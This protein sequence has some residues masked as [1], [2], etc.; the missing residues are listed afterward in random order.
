MKNRNFIFGVLTLSIF[1]L[2]SVG[3]VHFEKER[4]PS[5]LAYTLQSTWVAASTLTGASG[6]SV[7][8]TSASDGGPGSLRQALIDAQNG[9]TI[10]FDPTIF[11]P[12]APTK[13]YLKS[14][15]LEIVQGY[16]TIDASNAGVILDGSKSTAE[17]PSGIT[18]RSGGNTIRG[19]KIINFNGPGIILVGRAQHNTIGGDRDVGTG[20]TGQGNLIYNVSNGIC[21]FDPD[22][23]FNVIT[24]NIIGSDSYFGDPR[25]PYSGI[26][27]GGSSSKN[28]IGPNNIIAFHGGCGIYIRDNSS[29]RNKITQNS[30][31]DNGKGITLFLGANKEL[32]AP[33]ISGFDLAAGTVTGNAPANC[34]VE[35][36]SDSNDEGMI[37]EGKTM[38]DENGI[39]H[40][41]KGS[42]LVGPHV[43][44]IAT[45]IYGNSSEFST[46]PLGVSEP[47]ILQT[48]N[49]M[50]M[51]QFQPK[52]SNAIEDNRLG[53]TGTLIE[54]ID[55]NYMIFVNEFNDYG[56]KWIH[57]SKDWGDWPEVE[58]TG[59]YSKY[60]VNS[61]QDQAVNSLIDNGI[62]INY[63][64]CYWN[65]NILAKGQDYSRYKTEE[66]IQGYL[67]YL[68]FIVRHFK[69][70]ID[71]IEILNEPSVR[72]WQQFVEVTDYIN[73]VRRA[74]TVIREE[75]PDLKIVVGANNPL[76]EQFDR[77]Y[78]F[79]IL[80]SDIMPLVDAVSWHIGDRH[81]PENAEEFYYNYPSLLQEIKSI[82]TSHGFSGEYYSTELHW[83]VHYNEHVTYSE[84]SSAKYYARGIVMHRGMGF[85]T[86]VGLGPP[87]TDPLIERTVQNL[88]TIMAGAEPTI[89][90]MK[91]QSDVTNM[92]NCSFSM[93]NGDTLIAL[94]T[95]G[96]AV[97]EDPGVKASITLPSFAAQDVIGIDTL[98]SLQ[99]P[100]MASNE[101]GNLTI[102]NLVV[103]DYP[104]IIRL[105]PIP[106]PPIITDL[107]ITPT[108]V[109]TGQPIEISVKVSN[110]ED[111]ERNYTL[112][113]KINGYEEDIKTI[114]LEGG[115]T[116]AVEFS[117]T[118]E[119]AESYL[120][121]LGGLTGTFTVTALKAAG[122]EFSELAVNP[123]QV[124]V[125]KPVT[126]SVKVKNT[127]ELLGN[128]TVELKVNG[129]IEESKKVTIAGG[130]QTDVSFTVTKAAAGYYNIAVGSLGGG[131]TVKS[132]G[133]DGFPFEG[134]II[135]LMLAVLIMVVCTRRALWVVDSDTMSNSYVRTAAT[136]TPNAPAM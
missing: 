95:D 111:R 115:K 126:V 48:S 121:E 25:K 15:L 46:I 122:F 81:S 37:Y 42:S 13:I 55:E 36:F 11:P 1:I 88:C 131:F 123:A 54:F 118:K 101:D 74:I 135:G 35:I 5:L 39:F 112:P 86:G 34:V 21:L 20:P 104:L 59:T 96:V 109:K 93:S 117:V 114:R 56:F 50:T 72:S 44:S 63:F 64:L 94:W 90:P 78:F 6:I 100:I 132:S 119:I 33:F 67:D 27:I 41:S 52:Q 127:G 83:W 69:G 62:K 30:I 99:Q 87:S 89:L 45:D 8:V 12:S 53:G 38:A 124:E 61:Y 106:K 120:V 28:V 40:F 60:Y 107:T 125:G 7:V 82:A 18:I 116:G 43:S 80:S 110:T 113:L 130:A 85:L 136:H 23:S 73:L 70:R 49:N 75:D 32:V 71:S 79:T 128:C 16:L 26:F 97:E 22:T 92:R 19:L 76:E 66:E 65:E 31:H 9:D 4:P 2:C 29:T 14:N 129:V 133:I 91:I 10:T 3:N 105:S 24:G 51:T 84:I 98:N 57:L 102:Q 103:R 68:R 134:V 47:L 58:N 77:E 17:Y 108:E